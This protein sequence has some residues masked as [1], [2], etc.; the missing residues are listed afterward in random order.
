MKKFNIRVYGLWLDEDSGSVLVSDELIAGKRILKFPG[1]GLE[2]GEGLSDAL[3]REWEEEL[4][5]S[6]RVLSHFYT[7][8]F[9]QPSAFDDSQVISIYYLVE[10]LD[11]ILLPYTNDREHFYFMPIDDSYF[12]GKISLPIDKIVAAMLT[13]RQKNKYRDP[14]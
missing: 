12:E 6:I 11:K 7:T 1:G 3:K 8:D 13:R 14:K 5:I 4:N 10:P 2:W 9:F